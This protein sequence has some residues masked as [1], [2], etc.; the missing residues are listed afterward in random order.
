MLKAQ[1]ITHL[2]VR[3]ELLVR[4]LNNNLDARQRLLWNR[5]VAE[6]LHVQLR[7]R[8]YALYQLDG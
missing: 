5:F 6:H 2:M 1:G 4:F 7:D 8:G 3:E